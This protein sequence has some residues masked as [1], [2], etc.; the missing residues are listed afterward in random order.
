M[1]FLMVSCNKLK[2][3]DMR[4]TCHLRRQWKQV[5]GKFRLDI[6]CYVDIYTMQET[7]ME[8]VGWPY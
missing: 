5:T 4:Y 3:H 7:E 1:G 2:R 8:P 6:E